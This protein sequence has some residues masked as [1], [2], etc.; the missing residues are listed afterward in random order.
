MTASIVIIALMGQFG[1]GVLAA[2]GALAAHNKDYVAAGAC[3]VGI[4]FIAAV[5]GFG[6]Y[7]I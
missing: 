6:I 1:A 7:Y 2:I 5:V 3:L 4:V